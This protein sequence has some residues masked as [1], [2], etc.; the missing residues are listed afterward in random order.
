MSKRHLDVRLANQIKT[1]DIASAKI[2]TDKLD[3]IKLADLMKGGYIV[4]SYI[5][6]KRV[7]E[8]RDIVRLGYCK[9]KPICNFLRLSL[10]LICKCYYG[11][12][13]S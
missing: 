7:T 10:Y 5:A 4:E 13:L 3:A 2:K 12:H 11:S 6:N 8:L 1:R 9:Y